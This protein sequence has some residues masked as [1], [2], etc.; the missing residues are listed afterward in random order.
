MIVQIVDELV[1]K[2]QRKLKPVFA[3]NTWSELNHIRRHQHWEHEPDSLKV[4]QPLY[5]LGE[6]VL[7]VKSRHSFTGCFH[8]SVSFCVEARLNPQLT[9]KVSGVEILVSQ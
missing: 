3:I 2:G 6:A 8:G 1:S 4:G 7:T 5:Q 9:H